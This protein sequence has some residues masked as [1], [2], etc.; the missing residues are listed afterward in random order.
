M[1]YNHEA[2]GLTVVSRLP[3]TSF[4]RGKR[5][6]NLMRQRIGRR[7]VV[8]MA[9]AFV[10][11]LLG[12]CGGGGGSDVP[13]PMVL[14]A[15]VADAGGR[16]SHYTVSPST[17]AFS[18]VAE[19]PLGTGGNTSG[20]AVSPDG[21]FAYATN[22]DANTISEYR[23][24]PATGAFT[25]NGSITAPGTAA[26]GQTGPM[27]LPGLFGI[28][29]SPS[30]NFA[31]AVAAYADTAS[32]YT[33]NAATGALT[34][35]SGG[36]VS[37]GHLPVAFA[38]SPDGRFAYVTNSS[39]RTVSRYTVDASRGTLA[40]AG[41]SPI[42]VGDAP[43]DF[44]SAIALSPNGRFAYVTYQPPLV[45]SGGLRR[46]IRKASPRTLGPAAEPTAGAIVEYAVDAST[47][48]LTAVR[49]L[50]SVDAWAGAITFSPSGGFAY[51]ANY[52]SISEY[53]VNRS[54]GALTLMP[55]NVLSGMPGPMGIVFATIPS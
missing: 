23:V 4:G 43:S 21:R 20:L 17:G 26:A 11:P 41:V 37:S 48:A 15:F 40:P 36:V 45:T 30:G 29:V 24:N 52:D 13:A 39:D 5:Q 8:T 54:T 22:G 33:I 34:A 2:G 27:G 47:G 32:A 6:A 46:A 50:S 7:A 10:M 55:Q 42:S 25:A 16:I 1:W 31:Y 44:P 14:S 35:V 19:S 49:S 18:A 28:T 12:G 38:L 51:V 53:T 9:A 3:L